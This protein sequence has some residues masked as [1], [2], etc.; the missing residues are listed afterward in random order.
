M[1]KKDKVHRNFADS[2]CEELQLCEKW[3]DPEE[4]VEPVMEAIFS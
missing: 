4:E 1:E 3:V 2:A